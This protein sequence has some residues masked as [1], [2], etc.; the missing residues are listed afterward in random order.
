MIDVSTLTAYRYRPMTVEDIAALLGDE[1]LGIGKTYLLAPPTQARALLTCARVIFAASELARTEHL[2]HFTL[3]NIMRLA[4][5]SRATVYRFFG[6]MEGIHACGHYVLAA[7]QH[8]E[9]RKFLENNQNI[10]FE[11]LVQKYGLITLDSM[12]DVLSD[13]SKNIVRYR[14]Q[15]DIFRPGHLQAASFLGNSARRAGLLPSRCDPAT[16]SLPS[17]A[18]VLHIREA[19][20]EDPEAI[21]APARRR[22]LIESFLDMQHSLIAAARSAG[23]AA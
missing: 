8:A 5:V 6:G 18:L 12:K 16:F 22:R 9:R 14:R 21:H 11:E 17:M 4:D 10:E 15:V 20:L 13:Y 1:R 19:W 3:P 7:H 23:R 2:E